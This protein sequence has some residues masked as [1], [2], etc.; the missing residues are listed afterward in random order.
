M[1]KHLSKANI[2]FIMK[3]L[4]FYK[5]NKDVND[6]DVNRMNYLLNNLDKDDTYELFA[7][8]SKIYKKTFEN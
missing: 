5:K 6:R 3:S 7:T 4:R 8:F 1:I 2:E